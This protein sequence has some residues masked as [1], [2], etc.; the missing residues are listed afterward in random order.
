[1]LRLE[2]EPLACNIEN[3]WIYLDDLDEGLRMSQRAPHWRVAR[4]E[5]NVENRLRARLIQIRQVEAALATC[6]CRPEIEFSA[7]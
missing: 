3:G 5:T 4:T 2:A 7:V 6:K 1:M